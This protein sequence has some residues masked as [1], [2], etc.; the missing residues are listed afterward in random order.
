[1]YLQK[2]HVHFCTTFIYFHTYAYGHKQTANQLISIFDIYGSETS[3]F[4]LFVEA[5]V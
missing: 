2:S 5:Y 1:M 4:F 3:I